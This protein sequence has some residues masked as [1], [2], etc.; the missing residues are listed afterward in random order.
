MTNHH[1]MVDVVH[2]RGDIMRC[3]LWFCGTEVPFTTLQLRLRGPV[4]HQSFE[5]GEGKDPKRCE[6]LSE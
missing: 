5:K 1:A 4:S 6:V 2:R 3:A